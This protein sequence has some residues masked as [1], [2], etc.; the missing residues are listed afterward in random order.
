MARRLAVGQQRQRGCQCHQCVREYTD[1]DR[2]RFR[3]RQRQMALAKARGE[4]HIG[5]P[6]GRKAAEKATS[7]DTQAS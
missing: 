2:A 3:E 5:V 6:R 7:D 4:R 1:E